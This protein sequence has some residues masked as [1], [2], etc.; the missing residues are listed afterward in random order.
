LS[1]YFHCVSVNIRVAIGGFRAKSLIFHILLMAIFKPHF[2]AR[3]SSPDIIAIKAAQEAAIIREAPK[4]R[5]LIAKVGLATGVLAAAATAA[6]AK[7]NNAYARADV[8]LGARVSHPLDYVGFTSNR[9]WVPRLDDALR[10]AKNIAATNANTVRIFEP[11]NQ[12]QTSMDYDLPRLCN[13]AEAARQNNLTLE[14]STIGVYRDSQ[15]RIRHNYVPSNAGGVSRYLNFAKTII[16]AVAG[17]DAS[18][19]GPNGSQPCVQ[20]PLNNLIIEDFNEV[21]SSSFNSNQDAAKKYAYL[22]SKAIPAL[23][24]DETDINRAFEAAGNSEH[25]FKL[26]HAIGGLA[27]GVH[28]PVGFLKDFDQELKKFGRGPNLWSTKE[29]ARYGLGQKCSVDLL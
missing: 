2:M 26:V 25:H 10:A 16:L 5:G 15:K 6:T 13:A 4:K 29:R 9:I 23:A 17:P 24:K 21:N 22:E 20:E 14:I 1:A 19:P 8:P 28:D 7:P 18:K 27:A 3:E 12:T 11:Y